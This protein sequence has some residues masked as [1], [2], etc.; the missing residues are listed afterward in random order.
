M[1]VTK[2]EAFTDA[3]NELSNVLKALAHPARVAIVQHLLKVNACI[4][5]ELV[6][7]LP[8]AQPTVSRHL[9]ELKDAGIIRGT[10]EGTK[11]NYCIDHQRWAEVKTLIGDLFDQSVSDFDCC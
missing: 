11:V 6:D 1:G 5:G 4:G 7:Q 2:S 3:Q 10:I 9:R 8:L